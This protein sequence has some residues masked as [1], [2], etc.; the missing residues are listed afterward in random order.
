MQ[1]GTFEVCASF[2]GYRPGWIFS[3]GPQGTGYYEDQPPINEWPVS[4]ADI[5]TLECSRK[6]KRRRKRKRVVALTAA[7]ELK[8]IQGGQS[9]VFIEG[10]MKLAGDDEK[11]GSRSRRSHGPKAPCLNCGKQ[12]EQIKACPFC[13]SREHHGEGEDG[14]LL[15]PPRPPRVLAPTHRGEGFEQTAVQ[16]AG[17]ISHTKSLPRELGTVVPSRA[18]GVSPTSAAAARQQQLKR[19]KDPLIGELVLIHDGKWVGYQAV[20]RDSSHGFYNVNVVEME[21]SGETEYGESANLRRVQFSLS[22]QTVSQGLLTQ[23]R[24]KAA[25]EN[26]SGRPVGSG[27]VSAGWLNPLASPVS[28]AAASHN[29]QRT[30]HRTPQRS[31]AFVPRA[32]AAAYTCGLSVTSMSQLI[33]DTRQKCELL[34]QQLKRSKGMQFNYTQLEP[35]TA[36]S[37]DDN[38][39]GPVCADLAPCA[40][41]GGEDC[42]RRIKVYEQARDR[43]NAAMC[44]ELAEQDGRPLARVQYD[45]GGSQWIYL[46]EI[47]VLE[48]GEVVWAKMGR[49]YPWWPAQVMRE[50]GVDRGVGHQGIGQDTMVEFLGEHTVAWV[51]GK[52]TIDFESQY[53]VYSSILENSKKIFGFS[54]TM[55]RTALDEA[56][57]LFAEFK[58]RAK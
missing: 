4:R 45:K 10:V 5:D 15:P 28:P 3:T 57:A 46:D 12:I 2:A 13:G 17:P 26:S 38:N 41:G 19:E 22:G 24:L 8:K 44:L 54:R 56:Q 27:S 42:V 36:S 51:H 39:R 7:D 34:R 29:Q 9:S 23:L 37:A 18:Q 55:V 14:D 43:W 6:G 20:V 48:L 30:A 25:V 52:S 11:V 53:N 32:N 58:S 31:A 33:G 50:I 1:A 47:N 40:T 21:E 35:I 49:R 16:T